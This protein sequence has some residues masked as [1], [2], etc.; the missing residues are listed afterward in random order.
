MDEFGNGEVHE[1]NGTTENDT[2]ILNLGTSNDGE[3]VEFPHQNGE[4]QGNARI[5]QYLM[6]C[7]NEP[8][9]NNKNLFR[10]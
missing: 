3:I 4:L 2:A 8:S 5:F 6:N 10:R 7:V 1:P 9:S